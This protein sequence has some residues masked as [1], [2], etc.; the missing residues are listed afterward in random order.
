MIDNILKVI[1]TLVKT[2]AAAAGIYIVSQPPF[3]WIGTVSSAV[4]VIAALVC[5][6]AIWARKFA[7]EFVALS[8]IMVGLGAYTGFAWTEGNVL[9]GSVATMAGLLITARGIQLGY[10]VYLIGKA[11]RRL[12]GHE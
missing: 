7:V 10:L 6:Y 8:F 11:E 4:M 9:R 3:T 1:H 12:E 5:I 2:F